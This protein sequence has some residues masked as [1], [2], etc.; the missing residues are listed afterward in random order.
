MHS[1]HESGKSHL[2]ARIA[3]WWLETHPI[4]EAFV[5]TSAPSA[6]QVRAILWREINRAHAKGNLSGRT[7][8]TEWWMPIAK[9]DGTAGEELVA[10]GRKPD[11][12]QPGAFQGIHA[13][14]VL[15]IFDEA[16]SM[17]TAL[18]DAADSLVANENSRFLAI[19]NPDDPVS[20]FADV[21]KP[22]SGWNTIKIGYDD[23]PNF[24]G[25]AVPEDLRDLL[26]GPTWVEEKRKKWGE[27][28][29]MFIAKVKG[30]FPEV[31]DG[32]LIAA[33]HVKAAQE[34]RRSLGSPIVLGVDVGAGG[35]RNV[36]CARWGDVARI[37]AADSQ[38]DTM[39]TLGNVLAKQ[40]E[41]G[42]TLVRID[43]NGVGKGA[44]DRAC[45]LG[46]DD[47]EGVNVGEAATD[48]EQFENLRAE[49]Y[50]ALRARFE[51]GDIDLDPEDEDLA[52]ELVA[53]KW[54]RSSRGRIKMESKLDMKRRGLGSP[55]RADA[56]MLACLQDLRPTVDVW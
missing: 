28:N 17:P 50:W 35:D 44:Y 52:A 53:L 47:F 40:Q 15:V 9:A 39:K 56:L 1:C 54:E 29:P 37:I 6:P 2:A 46:H 20:E 11:E 51:D 33:K 8:Q 3:A 42:A 23:T 22:G 27:T 21:C 41:T 18:W 24:T 32:G 10:Y 34:R 7:N 49:A 13:R 4:G 48:R 19:G 26:I 30:E 55:D 38:P 5:V 14:Y 16:G 36:I 31:T 25:E 45:E 43:K 12:F